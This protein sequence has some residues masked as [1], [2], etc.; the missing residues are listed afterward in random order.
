MNND[1]LILVAEDDV[2]ISDILM[3]YIKRAGMRTVHAADG[4]QALTLITCLQPDLVLLDIQL[5]R[6]DG[7]NVLSTLRKESNTPVIMVTALDQDIDKLMGL[8][9]GAD[10][11]IVKPFN[12]SEVV[13]R[14]EAVLRRANPQVAPQNLIKNRFMT[15]YP[16]EFY[17]EIHS[18]G[19]TLTPV[20]TTT[21]F[22]L[23]THMA[24]YPRRVFSRE[25][26]LN[27]CLPESDTL[28]RTVDSHMSKLRKKF[29]NCGISG[30]PESI[31]G[32]G[33]RLGEQK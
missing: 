14:I 32:M 27:A 4:E 2:E 17:V 12:P 30:V 28:D 24:K 23:L 9:L 18:N 22:K 6:V 31:R 1:K 21:E 10:D 7:W 19:Q 13:A 26:L 33:Y 29:E 15:L 16:D 3:S 5:P 11:Y 20:L 8:R 25:E